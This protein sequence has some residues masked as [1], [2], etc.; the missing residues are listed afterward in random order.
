M[1]GGHS[2]TGRRAAVGT[3]G[4]RLQPAAP[5][6]AL[7][8][9]GRAQSKEEERTGQEES[10]RRRRRGPGAAR[11]ASE[12]RA[13]RKETVP[14]WGTRHGGRGDS[15]AAA[16]RCPR[17]NRRQQEPSLSVCL[18]CPA[19]L[20]EELSGAAAAAT[21]TRGEDFNVSHECAS[22]EQAVSPG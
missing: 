3:G 21:T 13:G 18:P 16:L 12:Q 17:G 8:C 15:A 4:H 6:A 10:R 20:R 14:G 1:P 2:R 9:N 5:R 7:P 22:T 19:P 11:A